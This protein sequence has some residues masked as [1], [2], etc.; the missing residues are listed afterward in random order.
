MKLKRVLA[1][2]LTLALAV[3]AAGCKGNA[4]SD[5]DGDGD[6]V[7]SSIEF[8]ELEITDTK[9][10]FLCWNDSK[11]L[12]TP[13]AYYYV[14][15][16]KMKE[17]YGCELEF[18][19]TTWSELPTKAAQ[20][21]MSNNSPDLIFYRTE[22]NPLFIANGIV[23]PWDDYIDINDSYWSSVKDF[24]LESAV[25]GKMYTFS[26]V[27]MQNDSYTYYWVK[28]F[29]DLGLETPRQLYYKGEWTLSKAAEYAKLLTQYNSSGAVSVYGI[30]YE[31][32]LHVST[33]ST[34]VNYDNG[35]FTNN[36]RDNALTEFYDFNTKMLDSGCK[37]INKTNSDLFLQG[38]IAMYIYQQYFGGNYL[39]EQ[40]SSGEVE[41]AP[42]PKADSADEYYVAGIPNYYWLAKGAKN[43]GGAAAFVAIHRL[44]S[45][46]ID[47]NIIEQMAERNKKLNGTDDEDEALAAEMRDSEKFTFVY[48]RA[49]GCGTSWSSTELSQ[50]TNQ[51]IN[52]SK[53]WSTAVEEYYPL[54]NTGVNEVNDKVASLTE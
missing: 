45:G 47:E 32:A 27:G 42:A 30:A 13:S 54:L 12:K 17:V 40:Y 10:K 37:P 19:Q 34:Y 8:P 28:N 11:V 38:K 43:P 35:I 36:L 52:Y 51:V 9:V 49:N 41:F 25:N 1:L 29:E 21:V 48:E 15:N 6:A 31:N 24:N 50:L 53:P 5:G 3:T 4:D 33:G 14:L 22:D 23:Q 18:V 26:S 16:E 46:R 2:A 39:S 20:L 7:K 44:L